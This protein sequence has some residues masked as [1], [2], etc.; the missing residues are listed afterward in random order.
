M[1]ASNTCLRPCIGRAHSSFA[2][3][4]LHCAVPELVCSPTIRNRVPTNKCPFRDGNDGPWSSFTLQVGTPAQN[5][6]VFISGASP[7]TWVV[8]SDGCLVSDSGCLEGR[9]RT[10]NP[11][12]SSTWSQHGYY[13]LGVEQNLGVPVQGVFG[14]ETLG[15]GIQGSGGPVLQDQIV[16]AYTSEALYVGMFGTNPAPTNFTATD[17]GRPS[18]MS[19]LR[20]QNFIP[21][22]SF[23]YTAGN[24]YR[25]K[26]V[27]ASLTLGGYDSSL[28]TPNGLSMPA[29]SD[30]SRKF[31][32][33]IQSINS[34][35][36]NG[37]GAALL[38]KGIMANIDSTDPTIWLPLEACHAFEKAFNLTWDPKTEVYL[39]DNTLHSALQTQNATVTFTLG[40][41]TSGGPTTDITLPYGS[42]DL[43]AKPPA[44]NITASQ[45]YFPL[46][47]AANDSQY[48]LG[49]AFLQEA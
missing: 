38:Q 3:S 31:M 22:L 7:D 25:L 21:S 15:L 4:P 9:G 47:R 19:S 48:T 8:R 34:K 23:G 27:F 2:Y 13:Q 49:R 32:V 33:G 20:R 40:S 44:F 11:N 37:T 1:H 5:V 39:V 16:A 24:Q 12:A 18:Y 35:N 43:L 17:Q 26:Q 36:Q 10:F 28:F 30:P 6:R 42:F 46:R 29:A 14:N 41:T 45:R